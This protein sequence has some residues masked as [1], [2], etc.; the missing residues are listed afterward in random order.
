MQKRV[1]CIR[2]GFAV[3]EGDSESDILEEARNLQ[4]D[5]FDWSDPDE[6]QIVE[7]EG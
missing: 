2:Y 1:M 6:P 7:S 3:V 5:D 4:E